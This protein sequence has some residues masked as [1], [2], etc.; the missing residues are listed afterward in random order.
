MSNSLTSMRPWLTVCLWCC[1]LLTADIGHL[2]SRLLAMRLAAESTD[3][4]VIKVVEEH[5][6]LLLQQIFTVDQQV[7]MQRQVS[8]CFVAYTD[9][10]QGPSMSM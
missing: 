1:R 2:T 6:S 10:Q 4:N 3:V 9:L 8:L 7:C 5:P